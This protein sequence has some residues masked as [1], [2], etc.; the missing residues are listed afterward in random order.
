[1]YMYIYIYIY[2]CISIASLVDQVVL[3]SNLGSRAVQKGA[4]GGLGMGFAKESEAERSII[5]V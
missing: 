3:T 2:I 1:M 5:L 4:S